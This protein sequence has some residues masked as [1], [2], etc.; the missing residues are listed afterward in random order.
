MNISERVTC[1]RREMERH[2][3]DIYIVPSEDFHHSEYVGDYFKS[4]EYITGFTGS[5]GTAVFTRDHAGLWT[6][7]RYF[8]QAES[9]LKGS[10]IQLYKMG[11]PD[12]PTI[13]AFLQQNLPEQGVIGFDGRVTGLSLGRAYQEIA[14]S[15][16]GKTAF[17]MDLVGEVWS[18]RPALSDEKAWSLSDQYN[19][20]STESKLARIREKMQEYKADLHVL[21]SLDDI[22]WIFNMRGNDV[23]YSPV[24]LAYAVVSMNHAVLYADAS[25]FSD[26]M[27]TSFKDLGVELK[28]YDA[29]YQDLT[30]VAPDQKVLVDPKRISYTLYHCIPESAGKVEKPNPSILLK[31]VKNQTEV[32]NIRKAHLKDGIAHTKFMY[33]LKTRVGKEHMTEISVSDKLE[34]FRAEQEGYVEPS[35]AP[36]SAFGAHGAIVHY[37]ATEETNEELREGSLI[38]MDTGGHYLEGSTDITRTMAL[39]EV[40]MKE[41]EDFTLVLRAN[42]R[43][44]NAVFLDGCSGTAL[45]CLARE[46]FWKEGLNYNHGTGHGIGYLLNVHEPPINFRWSGGDQA[47]QKLIENM[48][49]TDEPGLYIAGSHGIRT[50]NELLVR[51]GDQNEYGQFMYFEVLTYVPIDLDAVLP[52]RMTQEE[53]EQ[54]NQYHQNVYEK[55]SP[56]LTAEERE[57][58]RHYT[59]PLD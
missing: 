12:T 7:G 32:E 24:I 19:G 41:K 50:E 31:S 35:F 16:K 23:A 37:S 49:I 52:E 45:D 27:K 30:S 33:W 18:D 13:E 43:L 25:K 14:E 26:E 29:I 58:L 3:V 20:E 34:S 15:K 22:A 11:E 59:R 46:V 39:G 40:S 17:D 42:L 9:E 57:W 8:L 21:S 6:D 10:G 55:I 51:R 44:A 54:L 53:K 47:S 48:V 36:I 56:Y 28:P 5:A 38:L 2:G 4:R 1:L